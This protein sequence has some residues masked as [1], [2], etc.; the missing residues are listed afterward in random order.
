MYLLEASLPLSVK[1]GLRAYMAFSLFQFM[2]TLF[3]IGESLTYL[4]QGA[5]FF[6][7]RT[8]DER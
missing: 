2:R 6:K 7:E 3:L 1:G 5:F 8:A 4:S